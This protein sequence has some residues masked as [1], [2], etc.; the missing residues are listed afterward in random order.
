MRAFASDLD[1]T[2]IYS[3]RMI[4]SYGTNENY[5]L[6]ETLNGEEISYI[7]TN[8]KLR[9]KQIQEEMLFIPVTTRT[10]E[11]Y[12]RIS[13]FQT[14]IE[15]EYAITSNG[16]IIL[17]CGN[18]LT[19][20]S[21]FIQD[22]LRDC[23]PLSEMIKRI[24]ELPNTQWIKSIREAD[25]LFIYLIIE[26]TKISNMEFTH[27]YEWAK[28]QGWQTSL[29]GRKLYLIPNPINKWKAV[30]YL[31][32]ELN[33]TEIYTAG[34]SLLDYDLLINSHFGIAPAHGE[35]LTHDQYLN[36]T[37]LSGMQAALE[38][39]D[40]IQTKAQMKRELKDSKLVD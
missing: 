40:V 26:R 4:D 17:K 34:D 30:H 22:S 10:I 35:V 21:D 23:L 6:V 19:E 9:L 39:I 16:G 37:S 20:W 15:P 24:Q 27:L 18:V 8:A 2:L 13:L 29:Q 11:Q 5:E 38:M 33:L 3:K 12:K 7:S 1:R 31:S 36:K 14:E 25:N 28:I 32:R